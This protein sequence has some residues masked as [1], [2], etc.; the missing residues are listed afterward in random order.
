M[1]IL[2]GNTRL[3]A[4]VGR[5]KSNALTVEIKDGSGAVVASAR[6]KGSAAVLFGFKNGG[7]SSYTLNAGGIDYSLD[8]AGTSTFGTE[9]GPLG[10]IVALGGNTGCRFEDAGGTMLA[11]M[12][13]YVGAKS[14]DPWRHPIVAADGSSLGTLSLA[15]SH[16]SMS[17]IVDEVFDE[18]VFGVDV[19]TL[20]L[21]TVGAVLELARPVP[22]ALGD[23]LVAACVDTCVLP[24]GYV[25]R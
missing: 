2:G 25:S 10:R 7:K 17:E 12:T 8:V 11:T 24:R 22:E 6:Q 15:R 14:D 9:A 16:M 1:P 20:K 4:R 18:I 21:P 23:L 5:A 13:P 3:A 19:T